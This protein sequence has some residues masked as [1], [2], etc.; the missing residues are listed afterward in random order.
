[1]WIDGGTKSATSVGMPMPRFT[2][3]PSRSSRAMRLAIT[4][5]ASMVSSLRDNVIHQGSRGDDVVGRDHADGYDL[6]RGDDDGRGGHRD[7]RVEVAR[8]ERISQVAQV[9]AHERMNERKVGVQ[10][11]L[12]QIIATID[13]DLLLPLLDHRTDPCWSEDASQPGTPGSD[14]LDQRALRNKF[15]VELAGDHLLLGLLVEADVTG[16]YFAEELRPNELADA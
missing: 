11:S 13:G 14:A 10:R 1:M 4:V 7:H 6:F 5:C 12:Q 9:I 8:R 16:N 15:H 2:S 3:M